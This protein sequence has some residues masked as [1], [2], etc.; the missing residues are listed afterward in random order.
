MKSEKGKPAFPDDV[1]TVLSD[2]IKDHTKKNAEAGGN[3]S[4]GP[5]AFNTPQKNEFRGM[6]RK[7]KCIAM[8]IL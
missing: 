1:D 6:M 8:G 5:S 2:K 3:D 7:N 4:N